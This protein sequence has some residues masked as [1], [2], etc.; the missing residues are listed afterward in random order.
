MAFSTQK[1]FF[2]V[3]FMNKSDDFTCQEVCVKL[4]SYP[5]TIDD[6]SWAADIDKKSRF[7]ADLVACNI[8][9]ADRRGLSPG[10]ESETFGVGVEKISNQGKGT[11]GQKGI[12]LNSRKD[13]AGTGGYS[14]YSGIGSEAADPGVYYTSNLIVNDS[15]IN[16]ADGTITRMNELLVKNNLLQKRLADSD[17]LLRTASE[18]IFEI[19]RIMAQRYDSKNSKVLKKKINE[20]ADA[21][22]IT[23]TD[24]KDL[25]DLLRSVDDM[26]KAFYVL[27]AENANLKRLIEKLSKRCMMESLMLEPEKSNDVSYLKNKIDNFAKELAV[28]RKA[29]DVQLK[30]TQFDGGKNGIFDG[31]V[32]GNNNI[33]GG[34]QA[35]KYTF[36]PDKDMNNIKKILQERN[37]LRKKTEVLSDLENKISQLQKKA[38]QADRI[39]ENFVFNLSEQDQYIDEM[40]KE[41]QEMQNYYETEVDRSKCN[42]AMLKCRCDE[43]KQQLISANC[44]IQRVKY[45]QMEIDTL[46]KE[47]QKRDKALNAYDCQ[48]QQ[49][50]LKARNFKDAGYRFLDQLPLL[51]ATSSSDCEE[52][53]ELSTAYQT[54]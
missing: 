36:S 38:D 37:A 28:L 20:L 41:M 32:S 35:D 53:G 5:S 51:S 43:M 30:T 3:P 7:V 14:S 33:E 26:N 47:L 31:H 22:K 18:E 24:E 44:A 23:A 2:D 16:A 54:E 45:Q 11:V 4:K 13:V 48:Y 29:E 49:L 52:D 1:E 50:M 10:N 42:E 17:D 39:S 34:R 6:R 8:P 9:I 27:E 21:K 46:H 15:L 12:H 25:Y 19:K 40:E